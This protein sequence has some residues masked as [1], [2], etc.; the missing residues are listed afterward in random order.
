MLETPE[1]I[2]SN[3]EEKMQSLFHPN[4]ITKNLY[5]NSL[6]QKTLSNSTLSLDPLILL[7][8]MFLQEAREAYL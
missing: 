4:R 3:N 5:K 1:N 2:E 8:G 6:K 7:L